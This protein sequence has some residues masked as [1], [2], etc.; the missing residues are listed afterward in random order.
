MPN[1]SDFLLFT[2][3]ARNLLLTNPVLYFQYSKNDI[4]KVFPNTKIL[5]DFVL[6]EII[7]SIISVNG[8]LN[9][10]TSFNLT[11]AQNYYASSH[12]KIACSHHTRLIICKSIIKAISRLGRIVNALKILVLD[13]PWVKQLDVSSKT[14]MGSRD[15]GL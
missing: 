8:D 14:M 6:Y 2:C 9:L 4:G 12:D 7:T 15:Q 1:C 5:K 11:L 10:P 13:P 3:I